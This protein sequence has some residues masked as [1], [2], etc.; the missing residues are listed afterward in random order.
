MD[1][2][3]DQGPVPLYQQVE[4][5]IR[6]KIAHGE[7]ETGT[8]LPSEQELMESFDVSRTTVRQALKLLAEDN[9]IVKV[10]GKGNFV[11]QPKIQQE[12]VS[13]QTISEVLTGAG[14]VPEVR[15]SGVELDPD[16]PP[17][18]LVQLQL[19]PGEP[20]TRV[21]RRHFVEG[22]PIA[23]AVIYLSGRFNWRFSANELTHTSVYS[24]LEEQTEIQVDTG[25]QVIKAKA[26]EAD[27]AEALHL[28]LGTPVL[29][30]ENT[31]TT[32]DGVPIEHTEFYFPSERYALTVSL[33]R[34]LSGVSLEEVT[35]GFYDRGTRTAQ[36][37]KK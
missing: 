15:V 21:R 18:V 35:A 32:A 33:R 8:A 37:T 34:T 29:H 23:Y 4:K 24:W 16:V 7:F 14:F 30:V 36:D 2:R 13:L 22:E 11:S 17:H 31:S 6:A 9:T 27:V 10:Q 5:I 12:L 19:E 20:I 1:Q 28:D 25:Y 3:I 26:A